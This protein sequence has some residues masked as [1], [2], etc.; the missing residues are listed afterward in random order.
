MSKILFTKEGLEKF[1]IEL[2]ELQVKRREYVENLKVAREMGDLSENAAY[3]V[4]RQRL[5]STDY[6]I[7][8]L[9]KIINNSRVVE[10]RGTN[11]INIGSNITVLANN[12]EQDFQ[13]VGSHE[14][15]LANNKISFFSPVGSS[16]LNKK[17]G[18]IVL[19][20]I[21]SGEIEYKIIKI[22]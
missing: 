1:Q 21:P 22:Y 12:K 7:R 16:L 5:S 10:D 8:Y 15:D 4:A 14:S 13:I 9:N 20:K 2:Q 11:Q 3:K 17:V 6:R 19:I 18:D